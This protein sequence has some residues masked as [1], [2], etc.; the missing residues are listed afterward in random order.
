M[1]RIRMVA[2]AAALLLM[3]ALMASGCSLLNDQTSQPSG[4]YGGQVSQGADLGQIVVTDQIDPSTNAPRGQTDRFSSGQSTIYAVVQARR[5][6]AGTS[7]FARW[8]RDGQ[9]FEDSD[10]VRANQTYEN[11]YVEFHL[12]STKQ[13]ID[14]GNYTVQIF[15][16]GNPAQQASFTIQ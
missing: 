10:P 11:R 14:P 1:Q 4:G 16:D 5:I 12:Q 7:I 8:S 9:P 2:R 13:Q 6:A 3:L 15:V